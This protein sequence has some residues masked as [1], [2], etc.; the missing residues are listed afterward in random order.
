LGGDSSLNRFCLESLLSLSLYSPTLAARCAEGASIP[1]VDTFQVLKP[2]RPKALRL[3]TFSISSSR[4]Y[5]G[6]S[7]MPTHVL[8]TAGDSPNRDAVSLQKKNIC[9]KVTG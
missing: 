5:L 9:L 3:V 4:H 1:A 7:T 6:V 8:M 2:T